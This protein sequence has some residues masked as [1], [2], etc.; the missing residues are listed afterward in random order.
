M[1]AQL[2]VA[3]GTVYCVFIRSL[4]V[5]V[6]SNMASLRFINAIYMYFEE[7]KLICTDKNYQQAIIHLKCRAQVSGLFKRLGALEVILLKIVY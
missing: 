6:A 2:G 5:I 7:I 3:R 1:S 4:T